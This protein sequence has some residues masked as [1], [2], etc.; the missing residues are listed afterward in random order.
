MHLTIQ[1]VIEEKAESGKERVAL[2]R[3]IL[4]CKELRR[5]LKTVLF[6]SLQGCELFTFLVP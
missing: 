6:P 2:R 5:L 4:R 1:N 3:K